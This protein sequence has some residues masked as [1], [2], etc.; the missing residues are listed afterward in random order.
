M[1]ALW[2]ACSAAASFLAAHE[3]ASKEEEERPAFLKKKQKT[4]VSLASAFPDGASAC[5]KKNGFPAHAP[6]AQTKSLDRTKLHRDDHAVV[7]EPRE[8][9]F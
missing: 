6:P 3:G 1:L 4:F 7:T 5:S 8:K 2:R 9:A